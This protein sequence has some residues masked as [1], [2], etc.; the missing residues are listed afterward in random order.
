[1][2]DSPR[3]LPFMTC[4]D[5]NQYLGPPAWQLVHLFVL[6]IVNSITLFALS[7]LLIRT[8]YHLGGNTTTI[9]GWEIERHETLLRRARVLGGYLDGPDGIRVKIQRQE[10]PYDIGIWTNIK[11]G[12]GSGNVSMPPKT[13]ASNPD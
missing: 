10:F 12:M 13:N 9:E 7:T 1:M 2:S 8:L 5:T 11:Q 4:V 6:V 3:Q